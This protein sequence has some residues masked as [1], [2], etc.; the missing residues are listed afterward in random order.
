MLAPFLSDKQTENTLTNNEMPET[1]QRSLRFM[2]KLFLG[3]EAHFESFPLPEAKQ[4]LKLI[5]KSCFN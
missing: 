3:Y 2:E 4:G 1:R 5:L